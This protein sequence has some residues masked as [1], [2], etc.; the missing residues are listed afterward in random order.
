MKMSSLVG[1]RTKETPKDAE[2]TSHKF[3]LRGGYIKQQSSGIFSMLPLGKR[4]ALKI[5]VRF[6]SHSLRTTN[7][8]TVFATNLGQ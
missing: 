5:D 2:L 7:T 8:N 3:L 1:R 6:R 4:I